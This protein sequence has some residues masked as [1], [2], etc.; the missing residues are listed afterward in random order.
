MIFTPSLR[1]L[2]KN[3]EKRLPL[4]SASLRPRSRGVREAVDVR[5]RGDHALLLDAQHVRRA[6]GRERVYAHGRVA[7]DVEQLRLAGALGDT[8]LGVV[9]EEAV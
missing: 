8:G 9:L 3:R 1:R 2:E 4:P 6:D 7:V 5:A